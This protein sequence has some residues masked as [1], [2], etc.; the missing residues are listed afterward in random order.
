MLTRDTPPPTN[1]KQH[2]H[3]HTPGVPG[4]CARF[5]LRTLQ[6]PQVLIAHQAHR[7]GDAE[8][9]RGARAVPDDRGVQGRGRAARHPR[10][11]R[12]C[13]RQWQWQWQACKPAA[14]PSS[15]PAAGPSSEPAGPPPEPAGP[16]PEPGGQLEKVATERH[17]HTTHTNTHTHTQTN[18]Q[19]NKHTS[20]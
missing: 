8:P 7:Q 15:E 6:V 14:G 10:Q 12:Q 18:K 2:K 3:T 13:H 4:V 19:T 5:A 11:A 1:M 9:C 20:G 17:P 16:P